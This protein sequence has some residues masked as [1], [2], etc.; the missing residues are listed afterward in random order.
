MS[1]ASAA[2]GEGT[3]TGGLALDLAMEE[4]RND[5][6]L[7]GS[8]AG[9]LSDQRHHMH[10]Q[11]RH[12]SLKLWELR[13][14]VFLRLA[15]L[16]V[17]L[18][19]ATGAGLM[20]WE[21]AHSNG[22]LIEPFSVPPDLAAKGLTGQAV[23]SQVLDRLTD[24]QNRTQSARPPQ[25]YA[26]NWGDNLRVE[27]P[28]T[29]IS[30]GEFQRFLREWLGHDTHITGEMWRT[31]TGIGIAA[32]AGGDVGEKVTGS[33]SELD[34]LV[35]RA[36]EN[37]YRVTQPY[38]FANYLDRFYQEPG[39]IPENAQARLDQAQA[40]YKRLTFDRSPVERA[41][42]WNGLGTQSWLARGSVSAANDYYRKSLAAQPDF[43]VAL[44]AIAQWQGTHGHWEQ[45]LAD[46]RR[47]KEL[48]PNNAL[49]G[50]VVARFGGELVEGM[51]LVSAS[52]D[53]PLSPINQD[54]NRR[55][56]AELFAMLHEPARAR[57]TLAIPFNV[58]TPW[59]RTGLARQRIVIPAQL[60]DWQG[61]AAAEPES[62]KIIREQTP[63]W[64][65]ATEFG[66]NLRP[67]LAVARAHLGDLAGAQAL[68]AA[69]P[70]D[71]Y[72]CLRARAQVAELSGRPGNADLW[73][74]RAIREAPSVPFA[75]HDWG[76]A[77]LARGQPDAAIEK[78]KLANRRG[79]HFA[80]PIEMWGEALMAKNQSHLALAKFAEAEKY[81]PNWGR[82]H[83]KWGQA[84]AYAGKRDEAKA[85]F[86]RAATL[87]LTPS[88]KSELAGMR[89]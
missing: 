71:C 75:Y 72:P 85:Q 2:T 3:D 61:V 31:P 79:P 25:S 69:S 34:D 80:D 35:R 83:L 8:V 10:E 39:P 65:F 70:Q 43:I 60:E 58:P 55:V 87:D 16:I 52:V 78:F 56:Q 59:A 66:R 62:E 7:R 50:S 63:G 48:T 64:D 68:A 17:G 82:L 73:F 41:W 14:G 37:V 30:I 20:V 42:A 38:R 53:R 33:E 22:L 26:N 40:I 36:A 76:R 77:L 15:T 89:R 12:M 21:A 28:E 45:A 44:S 18:A 67:L 4:A 29:G 1:E 27:I 32:R 19:V 74:A 51:R 54:T 86:S 81:A 88:E 9:F 47:F 13:M 46:S 57:A 23:A 11:E 49:A 84:L 5:P 24:L 6:S